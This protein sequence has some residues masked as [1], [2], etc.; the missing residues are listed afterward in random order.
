[1]DNINTGFP[2][3]VLSITNPD[4]KREDARDK[5]EPYTFLQFIKF[6]SEDYLPE[7]LNT[8]YSN[9]VNEWNIQTES[10]STDNTEIIIDRY[11]DFLKDITLNFS[12]NAEKKFLTQ[13]NFDDKYDVQTAMSFY[14]SK[15]RSIIL[16]YKKKRDLLY[17]SVTKTKVKG[18]NLGAK[19]A[20]KDVVLDFLENRSTAGIDYDIDVIKDNLS[21]SITEYFDNYSQYFNREP[22][23]EDYGAN[24]KAYEPGTIPAGMNL[25]LTPEKE[26]VDRVFALVRLD[27]RELK[28]TDKLFNSKKHQTEKFMGTDFYYL[29]TDRNGTPDIGVLFSADKPYANFLNQEYPSTASVFSNDIISERDLGYF[30]PT[31]TAIATIQGKRIDFYQ[32]ETYPP[33][34]LYIFPD[35]NLFT[36]NDQVLTFIVDTSTSINNRSKGIAINQPNL[37][38][39][40]TGFIGYTSEINQDRN[41][42]T[43]LSYLY[44]QGYIDQSK[45][46]IF[47]NIFGL[48]KDNNYYRDNLKKETKKQIKSLV[49][50]GYQFF[51]DLYNE[52]FNFDYSI[53]DS[54]TFSQTKRSGITSFT[55]GLTAVG[56]QTPQLPLSTY[57]IF[58]RFY[59]PYQELLEPTNFLEVDYGRPETLVIDAD[60][61]DGAYFRMSETE[62]LKQPIRTGLSAFT[63][64]VDQF[65]FSDLVEAGI[66]Y[67]DNASTVV[68]ALCDNTGPGTAYQPGIALYEGL[69]GNFTYN[70]RL[71]GDNNVKNYDGAKFTDDIIFNY[72]QA[73]EGFDYRDEVY[74]GTSLSTVQTGSDKFFDKRNHTGKIYVKNIN[75]S[76][77]TPAV[78]EL[79][80]ALGY[81]SGKYSTAICDE[82]STKVVDF[83][84][85]YNTL[86]I[87]TSS[88]LV[89]EKTDYEDNTFISPRTF[90]NSIT[91]NTDFFDKVSNRLKVNNDVYFCKMVREQKTFKNILLYPKI[92]KYTYIEDKT[93]QIYPTTGNPAV[94]SACFFNISSFDVVP[95]ECSKPILTYSSDNEQFNLAVLVKDLNKGPELI[96]YLFEHTDEV[97]FLDS[98]AFVSNNSRF[99]HDFITSAGIINLN[100]LRF[101][102]SSVVPTLCAQST[103][104]SAASLIL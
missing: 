96:N 58:G 64:S 66:G 91:L 33:G 60:V 23:V 36:N 17:Y 9:Y 47:G 39:E 11:R 1:M 4:V 70:V 80:D 8:F 83:D 37:T 75:E 25:F 101:T 89:T 94:S 84:I 69:S 52:G 99:T 35:P 31:N 19:Q 55:N 51:D 15:I 62:A 63:S 92:Y 10:Q 14:S 59:T 45:K 30:R 21:V 34:A 26:I 54:S 104:I 98:A 71:S 97:K 44:D 73:E 27:I 103:P 48:I 49:L 46:D 16:Y 12:T 13:L 41:L 88:Y 86:F 78:K 7:T 56:D 102:L 5:F 93:E 2:K 61:K 90:T 76:P 77:D 95:I 42:N 28:E 65:Y 87:E 74:S 24:F 72:T 79:T 53:S 50:N 57:F 3:V 6:V 40:S 32:K 22:D 82:L 68:R 85:L 43:D 18:S 20:I 38:K 81:F 67:Y 29:S 100:S